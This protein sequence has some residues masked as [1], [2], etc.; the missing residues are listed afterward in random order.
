MDAIANWFLYNRRRVLA[1]F[2][3]DVFRRLFVNAGKLLS[4]NAV[5]AVLG[6]VATVLTARAL[7]PE[8]FGLLAVVTAYVAVV[9]GLATFNPWAA[10]IK[11]GAEALKREQPHEFMAIVKISV[12]LDLV[13]AISGTAIAVCG[14]F[15]LTG[16]WGW[17]QRLSHMAAVFSLS[18]L[19]NLSGTPVGILRLVDRFGM[20]TVQRILTAAVG[21]IGV[22][23]VGALGGGV[24][25]FLLV[26]LIS[27]ITGNAFLM[28]AAVVALWQSG[29]LRHWRARATGWK[30]FLR[31]SGWTYV[32]ATLDLPVK[33]LDIIIVSAVV[34]F[35][36]A[37]IYKIIKGILQLLT[38][39]SDPLQQ[40]V[41]PQFA[42]M[43]VDNDGKKAVKY[44]M[45]TGVLI[46]AAVGPVA[47][48]LAIGSPWWFGRVFGKAFAGGSLALSILL[49][50]RVFSVTAVVIHPL[51][52]ALGYV[53]QNTFIVLISNS[54]YLV[55]A[56][57]LGSEFGLVGFSLA[58][59]VSLAIVL[60]CKAVIIQKGVKGFERANAER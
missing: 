15:F 52:L 50:L 2:K 1:W 32:G 36:A 38:L 42:S 44:A 40:A 22:V 19:F 35:E 60:T 30:P 13:A 39:I 18:I 9:Q 58:Y 34:S 21:L 16:R 17:D 59:G 23:V 8:L 10:L 55:T 54:A 11:Y 27:G 49:L 6:L 5:A 7:G 29:L 25:W 4:A 43:I 47:M 56:Y 46:M 31:F 41:Y 51:F 3:D 45:R 53:K 57:L 20:F 33:H 28:G 24:W 26:L 12:V 48:L 37:G 14:A